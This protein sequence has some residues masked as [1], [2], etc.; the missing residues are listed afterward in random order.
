MVDSGP[1]DGPTFVLLHAF[2]CTGLM[3]WYP[4]IDLM[5]GFGRVVVL[6][7]RWHGSGITAQHFQLEDC[8]DDVVALA[9][10]LNIDMFIPVG[11]SM[12]SLVSQLVWRRHPERV[13]ALVLCATTSTFGER[14]YERTAAALIAGLLETV[15]PPPRQD[16]PEPQAGVVESWLRDHRWLLGQFRSTSAGNLLRSLAQT[17]RFDSRKW[18]AEIDVP[19]SVLI[20]KR[21]RCI[22]PRHQH[23]VAD[24]IPGA[25]KVIVD[26]GHAC[27]TLQSETFLPGLQTAVESVA[28]RA[29]ARPQAATG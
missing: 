8:A 28:D 20:P 3:T 14:A 1:S 18:V 12:G 26:A 7:Q 29:P 19:T 10:E 6:D 5:R 24:Q 27:C 11:F 2:A 25:Q 17:M 4:A 15:S 16:A 13:D 23:W 21:D 9:D 22:P